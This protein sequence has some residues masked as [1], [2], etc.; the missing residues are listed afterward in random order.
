MVILEVVAV[1]GECHLAGCGF[2][3]NLVFLVFVSDAVSLSQA[4]A[5]FN[6]LCLRSVD[7]Y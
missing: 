4:D 5:S 3:F 2:S 7:I 6:V 1:F